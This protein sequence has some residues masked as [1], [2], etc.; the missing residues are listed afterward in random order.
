MAVR[1]LALH[2]SL[3]TSQCCQRLCSMRG[4]DAGA[5][6]G[7]AAECQDA[8]CMGRLRCSPL[9]IQVRMLCSMA[10]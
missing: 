2:V 10:G 8:V 9:P 5:A 3:Y 4:S 7:R 6:C 1:L